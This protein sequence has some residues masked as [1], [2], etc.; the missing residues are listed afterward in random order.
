MAGGALGMASC[1]TPW[2]ACALVWLLVI[3]F[4]FFWLMAGFQA[5][6]SEP[7]KPWLIVATPT[8]VFFE[9]RRTLL[10]DVARWSDPGDGP[11]RLELRD[12]SRLDLPDPT[13]RL[14][15]YAQ[16]RWTKESSAPPDSGP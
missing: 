7:P 8:A 6:L 16:I 11:F 12:G 13:G 1:E 10:A 4:G 5:W 9:G 3:V 15:R 2:S 14:R